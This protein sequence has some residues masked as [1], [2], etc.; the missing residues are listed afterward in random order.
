M[1]F[2]KKNAEVTALQTQYA[3]AQTEL[4]SLSNRVVTVVA[5]AFSAGNTEKTA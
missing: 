1:F 5:A 3:L 4:M 2:F